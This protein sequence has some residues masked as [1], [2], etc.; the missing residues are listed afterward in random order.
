MYPVCHFDKGLRDLAR[1]SGTRIIRDSHRPRRKLDF[2]S[3]M[4]SA[5]WKSGAGGR[6]AAQRPRG[7]RSPGGRYLSCSSSFLL[8]SIPC[9]C[10][11]SV[12]FCLVL[13]P[14]VNLQK[15]NLGFYSVSHAQFCTVEIVLYWMYSSPQL[16][17]QDCEE[18]AKHE[19]ASAKTMNSLRLF[20]TLAVVQYCIE[21]FKYT[22]C[23]AVQIFI[24]LEADSLPKQSI[25]A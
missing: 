23:V 22:P 19:K 13:M 1:P 15:T 8:F 2:L 21:F 17:Y 10:L 6:G 7:T 25:F 9:P 24:P 16:K 5:R 3:I 14:R 4:R 20:R 12:L 18:T 11:L